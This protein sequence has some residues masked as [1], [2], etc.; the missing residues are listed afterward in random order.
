VKGSPP[1]TALPLIIANVQFHQTTLQECN[2]PDEIAEGLLFYESFHHLID[3]T[4]AAKQAFRLLKPG[5]ILCISG[6]S[7]WLPGNSEQAS[8]WDTERQRFGTLESPFTHQYLIHV[9]ET[10]GFVE[11]VRHHG[12]NGWFPLSQELKLIRDSGQFPATTLNNVTAR[13]RA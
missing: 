3:E 9:L 11:V 1:K 12:I 8:F 6:D 7:N 13:R 4:L 5:G 10:A 2:L